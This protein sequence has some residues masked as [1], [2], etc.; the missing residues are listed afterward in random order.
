MFRM[1]SLLHITKNIRIEYLLNA[2]FEIKGFPI[3]LEIILPLSLNG[4]KV[5]F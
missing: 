1:F 3:A 5:D 4:S 2:T